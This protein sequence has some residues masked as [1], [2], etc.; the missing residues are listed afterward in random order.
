MNR[1][2][3]IG[4]AILMA[5]A[6]MGLVILQVYWI[7]HDFALRQERFKQ[8]VTTALL[9]AVDKIDTGES[10]RFVMNSFGDE[11]SDTLAT[12]FAPA[13]DGNIP[14][15]DIME[16]EKF[17]PPPP[18]DAFTFVSSD[19]TSGGRK[20][21]KVFS[22]SD[23]RGTVSVTVDDKNRHE[24]IVFSDTSLFRKRVEQKVNAQVK[25]IEKTKE[26][27][28]SRK[29]QL[30]KVVEK[31]A[32]EF[33]TRDFNL[34]ER[35]NPAHVD[36]VVGAELKNSGITLP[37]GI[38]FATGKTDSVIWSR[39]LQSE[40]GNGVQMVS[41]KL[42][43]GE[44]VNRNDR[45]H[46]T[47]ADTFQYLISGMWMMLLSSVIF[48]GIVI[49]TF[50]YTVYIIFRQKKLSEM[51][52]DFINNMTHE[53]KTPIATIRLA[54]DSMQHNE[55]AGN[56]DRI[57]YYSNIIK[58][59]SNRMNDHVEN[60]LQFAQ[61]D[62]SAFAMETEPL[63]MHTI[64]Q[65]AIN[66]F[67]LQLE[68]LNGSITFIPDAV[69][70]MVTGDRRTLPVVITNLLD[71]A[72][73]YTE[74]APDIK[75]ITSN[76]DGSFVVEVED[77]GIGMN[78]DKQKRVFEKFYRVPSGNIHKVKGFGLGLSYVK[79]IVT[80]HN[81]SISVVSEPGTGSRFTVTLPLT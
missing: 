3:I 58:E 67:K 5:M 70:P 39:P 45:I 55:V 49:V 11:L 68:E 59:E 51:K 79:A 14:V 74:M 9:N 27:I 37:Y 38:A 32:F 57:V 64:I 28:K 31:M 30:N 47:F 18:P 73:K 25:R 75:V 77:N 40:P 20:T 52:S 54:A 71:N 4:T 17:I 50:S 15:N 62:K 63:N 29:D 7:R 65:D 12:F 19:D 23:S 80:A 44:I 35:I 22:S 8:Q 16:I 43:P 72:V 46:L 69:S 41:V 56:P 2:K 60:I 10:V 53:F 26:R 13:V 76:K 21:I 48:T 42:F 24:T 6:L 33:E 66:K 78:R 1:K 36:S 34:A 61:F 81:G